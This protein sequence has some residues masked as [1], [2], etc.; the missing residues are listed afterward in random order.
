[1]VYYPLPWKFR[2]DKTL[3]CQTMGKGPTYVPDTLYFP[4]NNS[5]IIKSNKTEIPLGVEEYTWLLLVETHYKNIN[6]HC[7]KGYKVDDDN[8]P[9]TNNIPNLHTYWYN[10]TYNNCGWGFIYRG[11]VAVQH[12]ERYMLSGFGE[13][14][15]RVITYHT[16]FSCLFL[17]S[18][19]RPF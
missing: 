4:I 18:K 11:K 7:E 10:M 8:N 3:C 5:L 19:L 13:E 12:Y 1:M 6:K 17:Y 14:S 16:T 15:L 2:R 9:V